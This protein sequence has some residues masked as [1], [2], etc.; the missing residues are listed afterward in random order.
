MMSQHGK[1]FPGGPVTKTG[2]PVPNAR[3]PGLIPVW[4]LDLTCCNEEFTCCNLEMPHATTKTWHS[5]IH[6]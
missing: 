5:Q 4:E 3:V 1:D 6:K 2:G